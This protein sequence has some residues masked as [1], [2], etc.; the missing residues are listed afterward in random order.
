MMIRGVR[1]ATLWLI[2]LAISAGPVLAQMQENSLQ[3]LVGVWETNYVDED[4]PGRQVWTFSWNHNQTFLTLETLTYVNDEVAFVG[5]GFKYYDT[6]NQKY[7]IYLMMDNGALH[8]ST[9]IRQ[10]DG[11]YRYMSETHGNAAFPDV[12]IELTVA[13]GAMK[14]VY[15]WTAEDGT[16][17]RDDNIFARIE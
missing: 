15:L 9:G 4:G 5:K 2:F 13:S 17:E 8:E 6:E 12:E 11:T 14:V 16:Q 3:E 7:R 1:F 10:E